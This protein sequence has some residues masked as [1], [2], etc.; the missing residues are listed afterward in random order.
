MIIALLPLHG[1]HS[2]RFHVPAEIVSCVDD[3]YQDQ[4]SSPGTRV[5]RVHANAAA[6]NVV[7]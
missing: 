6:I 5:E 7:L 3:P 4:R 2:R 1:A